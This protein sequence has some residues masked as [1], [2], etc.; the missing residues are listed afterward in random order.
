MAGTAEYGGR[1]VAIANF[2]TAD[3]YGSVSFLPEVGAGVHVY[4]NL[5]VTNQTYWGKTL[6]MH[7]HSSVTGKHFDAGKTAAHGVYPTGHAGD[8]HNNI[9]VTPTGRVILAFVDTRI[10]VAQ[11]TPN[12]IFGHHVVIHTGPDNCGISAL[13]C[14]DANGCAGAK[15]AE[16]TICPWGIADVCA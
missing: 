11:G 15:L 13:P 10:S 14:A 6:G 3:V 16:A 5:Q 4:A 8:L 2:A 9:T 1:P 7:I 12:C